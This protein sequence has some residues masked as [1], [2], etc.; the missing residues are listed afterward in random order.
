MGLKRR[1]ELQK[2][3]EDVLGSN[4]VYFQPPETI[5]MEYPCI[6][7]NLSAGNSRYADNALYFYRN[8]YTVTYIS[9]DPDDLKH[10][11]IIRVP[12]LRFDRFYT[13]NNLNHWVYEVYF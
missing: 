1:L 6:V 12:L 11:D 8:R 7:Y 13:S 3:L 4:H 10:Y 2:L 9:R 5:K